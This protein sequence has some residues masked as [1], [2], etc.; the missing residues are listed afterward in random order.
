VPRGRGV[1]LREHLEQ[2]VD[3]VR[4]DADAGVGDRDLEDRRLHARNG[5]TIDLDVALVRELDRVAHQVHHDLAQPAGV[6]AQHGRCIGAIDDELDTLGGGLQRHHR[7]GLVHDAAQV[8]LHALELELPGLDLRQVEHVVDERE[9]RPGAAADDVD[10]LAL[11]VAER[12]LGEHLDM[13]M[14][15]FMGV[16]ISWLTLRGSR[17]WRDSRPRRELGLD[18][19]LFGHF[20]VGDELHGTGQPGGLAGRIVIGLAA[21]AHPFVV[22]ALWAMRTSTSIGGPPAR[23]KLR[24]DR[25][26][27]TS[28][29][30]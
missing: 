30:G 18:S 3:A 17:S 27:S 6:A 9:Q 15:P 11:R 28:S 24:A 20:A 29:G 8:E 25:A 10:V 13:P 26:S 12:G 7:H 22:P 1:D 14:T 19:G 2:A 23:W 21:Q 4:G 16:R 5:R